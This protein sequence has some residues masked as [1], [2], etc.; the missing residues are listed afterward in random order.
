MLMM[1]CHLR[2]QSAGAYEQVAHCVGWALCILQCNLTD[3][4]ADSDQEG[5][6][7]QKD[8]RRKGQKEVL[9]FLN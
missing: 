5:N 1:H 4:D 7:G 8:H 9:T 6:P 2:G 3:K